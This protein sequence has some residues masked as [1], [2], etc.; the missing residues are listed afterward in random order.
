MLSI[1]RRPGES[2]TIGNNITVTLTEIRSGQ[3]RLSIDAPKEVPILRD[4]ARKKQQT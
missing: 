1:S 2:V 4:D 3:V